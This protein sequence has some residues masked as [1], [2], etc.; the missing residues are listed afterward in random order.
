MIISNWIITILEYITDMAEQ[1]APVDDPSLDDFD[2]RLREAS[3][4]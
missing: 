1:P 2:R 4:K 3:D